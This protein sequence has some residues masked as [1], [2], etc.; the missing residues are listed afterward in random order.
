MAKHRKRLIAGVAVSIAVAAAV[1]GSAVLVTRA[2][3]AGP[4]ATDNVRIV[5]DRKL[6]E[7]WVINAAYG[8]GALN[9]LR[10]ALIEI[11][12]DNAEEAKK[13]IAVAQSLLAKIKPE[14]PRAAGGPAPTTDPTDA[15]EPAADLIL[16]HSQVRVLGDAD[17]TNSVQGKLDDIRRELEMNDHEAIITALDSLNMPLAY[18]RIDMPLRE[19]IVLVNESLQALDARD[20]G[21]ARSKLLAVGDVLRIETVRLGVEDATSD[22]ERAGDAG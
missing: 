18:T 10:A 7:Q 22:P 11:E 16:V 4:E 20:S 8:R 19:T 5:D 14:S 15:F 21:G 2:S 6:P 17:P 9:N 12:N 13:G 3:S 1:V